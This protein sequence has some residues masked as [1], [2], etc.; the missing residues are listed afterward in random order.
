MDQFTRGESPPFD[1]QEEL[2]QFKL[3]APLSVELDDFEMKPP[4]VTAMNEIVNANPVEQEAQRKKYQQQCFRKW[5]DKRVE[6]NL[7][8]QEDNHVIRAQ[9][10]ELTKK[11]YQFRDTAQKVFHSVMGSMDEN[12]RLAVERYSESFK[13][14]TTEE[15][16]EYSYKDALKDLNWWFL[17]SAAFQ[18][19]PAFAVDL[20]KDQEESRIK[21]F[22]H[23]FGKYTTWLTQL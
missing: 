16:I 5:R 15:E 22:K 21:S 10:T 2:L 17:F 9:R 14:E 12:S 1:L 19:A 11:E 3:Q 7:R 6:R 18:D 20:R 13:D 23:R 8:I 4:D